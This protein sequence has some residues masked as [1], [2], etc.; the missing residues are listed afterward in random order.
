VTQAEQRDAAGD[1]GTEDL[2][3]PDYDASG[4]AD[5]DVSESADQEDL[6]AE[7]L[8]DVGDAVPE[9]ADQE[10]AGANLHADHL[11]D[12]GVDRSKAADLEPGGATR[13]AYCTMEFY[14]SDER[15]M[16]YGRLYHADLCAKFA[17][18]IAIAE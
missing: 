6:G 4:D 13:C 14:S 9:A 1:L 8:E 12:A 3:V 10:P 7:D 17:K 2:L 15:V 18:P 5:D 16:I 11:Q